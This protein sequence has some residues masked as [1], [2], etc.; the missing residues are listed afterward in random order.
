MQ[1]GR[2]LLFDL[3]GVLVE[4][5][6]QAA[7]KRLLPHLAE[8]EILARWLDSSAVGQFERGAV[9]ANEFAHLFL[10]EWQLHLEPSQFLSEFSSWVKGFFPG[11]S[12]L[13]SHL[14]ARHVVGCLSNTNAVHWIQ[15]DDVRAAFDVC[16]ASHLTG[17]MKPD[18]AAFEHALQSL[19]I[20]AG[21]VYYFDD[22]LSNVVAARGLGINA[23]H[24]RGLDE[25]ENTLQRLD[26]AT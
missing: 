5:V 20:E 2:V 1:D 17:H 19:G 24:V 18:R 7:L 12:R 4:S 14:R 6:G 22:L 8:T 15:L 9:S 23:F 21:R 25:T 13:L 10:A 3:G 26:F 16:I 11:A